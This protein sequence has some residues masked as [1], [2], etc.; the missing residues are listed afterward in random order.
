M[1][2][3]YVRA[4]SNY[5]R[6]GMAI[7]L[8]TTMP[9]FQRTNSSSIV[10]AQDIPPGVGYTL[11][12]IEYDPGNSHYY[13]TIQAYD[14]VEGLFT[15]TGRL[16]F[17]D[18]TGEFTIGFDLF[19]TASSLPFVPAPTCGDIQSQQSY[20]CTNCQIQRYQNCSELANQRASQADA[21][22]GL[23]ILTCVGI[24]LAGPVVGTILA[25]ACIAAATK[26]S[27]EKIKTIAIERKQCYCGIVQQC[28]SEKGYNCA[29]YTIYQ[30]IEQCP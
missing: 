6:V 16:F 23:A 5:M 2:I 4:A 14:A 19:S 13:R 26:A 30:I 12:P 3:R 8:M 20:E 21:E 17:T 1:N 25:I 15:V 10:Q 27:M 29:P 28:S 18:A 11:G 24:G 22:F 9:I 7:V